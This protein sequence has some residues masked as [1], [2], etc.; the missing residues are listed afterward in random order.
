MFQY[1]RNI[2]LF[3]LSA[4]TLISCASASDATIKEPIVL[5]NNI[6]NNTQKT[7]LAAGNVI[8][9]I[10]YENLS[11]YIGERQY[12]KVNFDYSLG[13]LISESKNITYSTNRLQHFY[14]NKLCE[15]I[16]WYNCETNI[17]NLDK[18][19]GVN[20][21]SRTSFAK[22]GI[23]SVV[24]YKVKYTTVDYY[25]KPHEVSGSILIPQTKEKLKGVVIAYHHTVLDKNNAPSNFRRDFFHQSE[26]LAGAMSAA[27]Y[28][29]VMPD[30]IGIGVN[31][32]SVHPYIIYPEVNALS[33]IYMLKLIDKVDKSIKYQLINNKVPVYLTG[34][35]EGSSYA[36]WA[37]KILQDN[38]E[39]LAK[40][41]YTLRRAAPI[42]GAYNL[43]KATFSSLLSSNES[44]LDFQEGLLQSVIRPGLT[45]NVLVSYNTYEAKQDESYIFSAK[46]ANYPES[47]NYVY[48]IIQNPESGTELK[49]YEAL[50]KRAKKAGYMNDGNSVVPLINTVLLENNS[51]LIKRFESADIY[52][53]HSN[54]PIDFITLQQDIVVTELNSYTAYVAM[55]KH[56]NSEVSLTIIP[57]DTL[58]GSG[59]LPLTDL[60]VNHSTFTPYGYMLARKYFTENTAEANNEH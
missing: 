12:T 5:K 54:T 3:A 42:S 60:V 37:N 13:N 27:G 1:I 4:L 23:E 9:S 57:N 30:Y 7:N 52:N 43:S 20:I 39:F 16:Y 11:S 59:L 45:A 29:V 6:E 18:F 46:F 31:E 21:E 24:G 56:Q 53:W 10:T 19:S 14:H 36:V 22:L 28:V 33:G 40:N 8:E 55:K 32:S 17:A 50:Y 34:Y 48:N 41:N 2:G 44:E 58:Y 35:S 51:Q 49:K 25:G 47:Q 38:P 15:N 26:M